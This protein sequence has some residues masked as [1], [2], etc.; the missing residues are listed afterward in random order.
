LTTR[1]AQPKKANF[2][3]SVELE[4]LLLEDNPLKAKTRKVN[5][6]N[7]SPE[8]KQMEEQ[9]ESI[10]SPYALHPSSLTTIL[11]TRFTPYDFKKMQRRSCFPNSEQTT[12]TITATSSNESR[13][14]TPAPFDR[15]SGAAHESDHIHLGNSMDMAEFND[16]ESV[17]LE[18]VL[19]EKDTSP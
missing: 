3:A 17:Q 16:V 5:Q 18:K 1:I 12:S 14:V 13:P 8:M 11:C 10:L 15:G 19:S 2:D 4:E 9:Y 7:L 6:S